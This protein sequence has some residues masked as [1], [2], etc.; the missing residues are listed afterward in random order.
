MREIYSE[1]YNVLFGITQ[2]HILFHISQM[3]SVEEMEKEKNVY[4]SLL[5]II[6]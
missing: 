6:L 2:I 5:V 3:V 1:D 4:I